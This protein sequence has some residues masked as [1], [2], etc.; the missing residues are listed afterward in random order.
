MS[1]PEDEGSRVMIAI[2]QTSAELP[3]SPSVVYNVAPKEGSV[4]AISFP[5]FCVAVTHEGVAQIVSSQDRS[6]KW[7]PGQDRIVSQFGV[8]P[9]GAG[10]DPERIKRILEV[11]LQLW[12]K[13][14]IP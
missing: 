9:D 14:E 5:G 8:G 3:A 10:S 6:R 13:D 4:V 7:E 12:P 1:E 2:F 11:S